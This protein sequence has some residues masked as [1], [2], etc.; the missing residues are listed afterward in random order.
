MLAAFAATTDLDVK[1]L[2]VVSL[3]EWHST[4]YVEKKP[5]AQFVQVSPAPASLVLE[6]RG[7]PASLVPCGPAADEH[8]AVTRV[9]MAATWTLTQSS[10]LRGPRTASPHPPE[11]DAP[12]RSARHTRRIADQASG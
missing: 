1:F 5:S 12:L 2:P 10:S 8:A 7:A 3:A 11:L 9:A 6:S 4:Q